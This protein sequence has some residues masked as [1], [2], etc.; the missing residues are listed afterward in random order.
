MLNTLLYEKNIFNVVAFN[1]GISAN[2]D[3]AYNKLNE[4]NTD[5]IC[6][7]KIAKKGLIRRNKGE[8]IFLKIG[9]NV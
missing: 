8:E 6:W 1:V 2:L 3:E 4:K 5:E 9:D 7:L